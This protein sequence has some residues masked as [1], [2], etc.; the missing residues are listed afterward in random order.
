MTPYDV[1]R[2]VPR[3]AATDRAIA[4]GEEYFSVLRPVDGS[5]AG[6]IQRVDYAADAWQ[7]PNEEVIGWWRCKASSQGP[8]APKL[9]PN[10]VLLGLF[11][12]WI[13]QPDRRDSRYV[14]ALLLV[15]RRVFR[16]SEPTAGIGDG[17]ADEASQQTDTD[18]LRVDCPKRNETYEVAVTPPGPDRAA[19]I[20]AELNELLYAN[21]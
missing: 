15:R 11:D 6:E 3:C 9:A 18:I 20:Q 7:P 2:G 5:A 4:P 13:D 16:L 1:K 17:A 12:E 8:G 10:E 19:T 21:E 14:L